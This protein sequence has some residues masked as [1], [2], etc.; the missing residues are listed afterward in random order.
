MISWAI[1]HNPRDYPGKYVA[2]AFVGD[3]P[4]FAAFVCD[5]LEEANAHVP[6]G[7]VFIPAQP[8]DHESVIGV[9]L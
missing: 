3:K 4:T 5:T 9:W 2:R 1:F 8:G 7:L 6:P